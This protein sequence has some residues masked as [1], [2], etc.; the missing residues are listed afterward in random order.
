VYYYGNKHGN[1]WPL[2]WS[3]RTFE[4]SDTAGFITNKS[5]C[6]MTQYT[7]NMSAC[8]E[9]SVVVVIIIKV[10]LSVPLSPCYFRY[11]PKSSIKML[12]VFQRH[13]SMWFSRSYTEHWYSC[14]LPT[15]SHCRHVDITYE[16]RFTSWHVGKLV[17]VVKSGHG[18][19]DRQ[20][21]SSSRSLQVIALISSLF[22][23][24]WE[25][26]GINI[27]RGQHGT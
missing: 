18:Q 23:W 15:S 7:F 11:L 14:S 27:C 26:N 8:S 17:F 16:M 1:H 21:Q 25:S 22:W 24:R 3:T 20:T 19:T 10:M 9:S 4:G 5:V 2:A 6:N 13:L 12:D